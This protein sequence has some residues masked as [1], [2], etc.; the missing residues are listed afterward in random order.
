MKPFILS[1][2]ELAHFGFL[3]AVAVVEL[4]FAIAEEL[5]SE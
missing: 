4:L 1:A 2:L 3:A 5:L